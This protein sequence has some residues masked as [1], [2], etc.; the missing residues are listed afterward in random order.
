MKK[1]LMFAGPERK[2]G[3]N[4]FEVLRG[5]CCIWK[6]K[7]ARKCVLPACKAFCGLSQKKGSSLP[8]PSC[9]AP[10]LWLL[11]PASLAYQPF[12]PHLLSPG[13]GPRCL[14]KKQFFEVTMWPAS[15]AGFPS[16]DLILLSKFHP[17][18]LQIMSQ[19]FPFSRLLFSQDISPLSSLT[20]LLLFLRSQSKCF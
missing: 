20:Q 9:Q 15:P 6:Y 3:Q 17:L 10:R 18:Y 14:G 7:G 13:F 5:K 11:P 19:C 8:V 4:V 16:C 12:L 1:I 2:I